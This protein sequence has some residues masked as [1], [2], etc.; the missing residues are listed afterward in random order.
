M[1]LY[2][3]IYVMLIIFLSKCFGENLVQVSTSRGSV[4]GV[5]VDYGSDT[6]KLYYGQ[7]DVFLGIPFANQQR[8]QVRKK[9]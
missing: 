6:S 2:F 3:L 7:A 5:H 8:F 1:K 4:V 9:S